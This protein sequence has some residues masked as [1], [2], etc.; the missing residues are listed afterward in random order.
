M[1]EMSKVFIT[2]KLPNETHPFY[3]KVRTDIDKE[4][5][6]RHYAKSL[7]LEAC[8]FQV[9]RYGKRTPSQFAWAVYRNVD[10]NAPYLTSANWKQ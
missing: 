7:R 9:R 2:V 8:K 1:P 6:A 5:D 4:S 10:D 3:D